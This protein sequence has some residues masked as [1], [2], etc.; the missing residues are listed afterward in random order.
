MDDECVLAL[1]EMRAD[2]LWMH[3]L[4]LLL[5]DTRIELLL[6]LW[7]GSRR[8][9]LL[10]LL[11]LLLRLLLL[12]HLL[13]LLWLLT[14]EHGIRAIVCHDARSR[15]VGRSPDGRTGGGLLSEVVG[16][17]LWLAST[18]KH[19]QAKQSQAECLQQLIFYSGLYYIIQY[20]LLSS[21][22]SAIGC[23]FNQYRRPTG[24]MTPTTMAARVRKFFQLTRW[25]SAADDISSNEPP[26]VVCMMDTPR[27]PN[28]VLPQN[29]TMSMP[30]CGAT[31]L[32]TQCGG[33]GAMRSR[34]RN[35]KRFAL[36]PDSLSS[37][38]SSIAFHRG[39]A[40]RAG[41]RAA[42]MA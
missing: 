16:S 35:E 10:L 1:G 3:P 30:T 6:I 11:L 14:R 33:S 20:Y 22:G 4:G 28:A 5:P 42:D 34:M 27:M 8:G 36:S 9:L 19:G 17:K 13:L 37:Q 38:R 39:R 21:S 31:T 41:P 23:S 32:T 26:M 2:L 7:I 15:V 18:G 40:R 29:G 24:S 25:K 12:L